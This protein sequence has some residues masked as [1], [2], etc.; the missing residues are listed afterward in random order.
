MKPRNHGTTTGVLLAAVC[1]WAMAVA[2]QE[3]PEVRASAQ[4]GTAEPGAAGRIPASK[5]ASL[6]AELAQK[7]DGTSSAR[8]RRA[9]RNII[10]EAEGLLEAYPAAP[11]RYR[12]LGFV[13][14]GQKRLVRLENSDR[15]RDA[16]FETCG[17]LAKAPD[18]YANVRLEADLLLTEK[19]L[20]GKNADLKQRAQALAEL[21]KR[22][23]NTPAEAKS[24]MIASLMA[25]KLEAADLLEDIR[26]VMS[27][28]FAGDL[29]LIEFQRA[30]LGASILGAPFRG[31]YMRADG[32]PLCFPADRMGHT[33]LLYFWSKDTADLE[34]R[35]AAWKALQGEYPGLFKVFSF[36]L[37]DLP[38]AGQKILRTM[39]VDW[40]AMRLPG[41]RRSQ[42]YRTYARRDPV[43][44]HVSPTG[45]AA[46]LPADMHRTDYPRRVRSYSRKNPRYL[47]QLQSLF[48]GEFLVVHPYE[49]FDAAL[50]PE[51]KMAPPGDS[52]KGAGAGLSRTVASVPEKELRAIQACFVAPPLRY[53]LSRDEAWANYEKAEALCRVAIGRYPE[54]PDLWIVRNRRIIALLGMWNLASEPKYLERAV[55]EAQATLAMDLPPGV[56]V[57]SQFCLAKQALRRD[58]ADSE[59]VLHA[60]IKAAGGDT[61]PGS[62]LAAAAILSL[63]ACAPDLHAS[64]RRTLLAKH[65]EDPMTW[66]VRCFLLD[67]LHRY[68]LF[69][70]PYHRGIMGKRRSYE[71]STDRPGHTG[72]VVKAELKA[73]DGGTLSIPRDTAGKWTIIVFASA[74]DEG[75]GRLHE[76]FLREASRIADS[77]ASKDINVI[78]AFLGDDTKR[79]SALMKENP[80]GAQTVLVP[81]G[82]RNPLAHRLGL[83]SAD[84]RPNIVLLRP[85]GAVG[86]VLSGLVVLRGTG[87]A[88][89]R[90]IERH[91][92][93]VVE[94]ALGSG[95]IQ[96][97]KRLAF[98]VAPP[99]RGRNGISPAHL[100]IRAKVYVALRDWEA[101]LADIEAA[102][103][104]LRRRDAGL[105]I[106][107]PEA[108]KAMLLKAAILDGLGQPA[109]ASEAR[110]TAEDWGRLVRDQ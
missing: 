95:G 43:C 74:W 34:Q 11:N 82:V 65:T 97:A 62:A 104:V 28:R 22:Y 54:A 64:Y 94:K 66:T 23:R 50:P 87:G 29:K 2:A 96:E 13:L 10:R 69:G 93:Q 44:V 90:V 73:L 103:G 77:R 38:D 88:L 9:Y 79:V 89:D 55:R 35:V 102:I 85:D 17:K 36:N 83:L 91:D 63:D 33:S 108:A 45:Y 5:I 99:D 84:L 75:A 100:R 16:L 56:Q 19:A 47:S 46:L 72:H 53:R 15:N 76:G 58:D 12:V 68:N 26:R 59:S 18:A 41:G 3:A 6:A 107:S 20:T 71:I 57:V 109:Q 70:A 7:D 81:G 4:Q 30:R 101:A 98:A 8:R 14:E 27:E 110:Q 40:T 37:D 49:P 52:P 31:T 105:D 25:T 78:A 39:G 42:T 61:A 48:V 32:T 86:A 106:R 67:R 1:V 80:W 24:L 51:L 21:I 60:F 92:E